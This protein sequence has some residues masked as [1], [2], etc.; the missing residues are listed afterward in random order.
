MYALWPIFDVKKKIHL[1]VTANSDQDPD[2]HGSEFVWLV[3]FGSALW[4]KAGSGSPRKPVRI[5]NTSA[6]PA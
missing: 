5:N 1:L 2:P 3:G 4:Q 6:P